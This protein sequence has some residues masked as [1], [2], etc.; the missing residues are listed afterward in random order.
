MK[1]IKNINEMIGV[2]E[3]VINLTKK[4]VRLLIKILKDTSDT[5]SSM[6]CNDPYPNEERIF[7][8]EERTQMSN[9]I[10]EDL[11]EEDIDDFLFN[12]QFVDYLIK[13][14]KSQR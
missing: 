6:S 10:N 9:Y 12:F 5:R 2:D 3:V 11:D 7:T 8:E 1:H 14:I 13:R 4:E